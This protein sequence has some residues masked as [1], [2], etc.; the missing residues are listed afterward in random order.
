MPDYQDLTSK[1]RTLEAKVWKSND[2]NK[3]T[4]ERFP[5]KGGRGSVNSESVPS[6]VSQN[7]TVS[8]LKP[9]V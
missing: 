5:V 4:N 6:H 3:L 7:T 1:I 8:V 2:N 9:V